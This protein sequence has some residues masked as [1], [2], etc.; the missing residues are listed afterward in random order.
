[1]AA[2]STGVIGF[3]Y[4]RSQVQILLPRPTTVLISLAAILTPAGVILADVV[5]VFGSA[6]VLPGTFTPRSNVIQLIWAPRWD[7]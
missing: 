1:L 4:S 6:A 5:T 2:L 3:G 7:P